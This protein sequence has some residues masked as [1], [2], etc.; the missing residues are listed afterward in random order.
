M[1]SGTCD[2]HGKQEIPHIPHTHSLHSNENKKIMKV[3]SLYGLRPLTTLPLQREIAL[4]KLQVRSPR[5]SLYQA[6]KLLQPHS[7]TLIKNSSLSFFEFLRGT[8]DEHLSYQQ[9]Q[10]VP[11][12]SLRGKLF[13]VVTLRLF[14]TTNQDKGDN[15]DTKLNRTTTDLQSPVP[16]IQVAAQQASGT[17]NIKTTSLL[18]PIPTSINHQQFQP[19]KYSLL[20]LII[21]TLILFPPT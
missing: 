17:F 10:K 15:K 13:G 19:N 7:S 1:S 4:G 12:T 18:I 3:L 9:Q 6:S 21:S 14:Y 5:G 11:V 2:K 8:E 20:E 16:V